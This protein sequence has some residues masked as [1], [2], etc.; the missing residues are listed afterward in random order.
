MILLLFFISFLLSENTIN[1]AAIMGLGGSEKQVENSNLNISSSSSQQQQYHRFDRLI[2]SV[3]RKSGHPDIIHPTICPPSCEHLH[4]AIDHFQNGDNISLTGRIKDECSCVCPVSRPVYLSSAGSCVSKLLPTECERTISW[5]TLQ[6]T[7]T[8]VPVVHLLPHSVVLPNSPLN[9]EK[10]GIHVSQNGQVNCTIGQVFY[11]N[12]HHRWKTPLRKTVLFELTDFEQKPIIYFRGTDTDS[13]FLAGAVVQI[14]L[15][16]DRDNQINKNSQHFCISLRIAGVSGSIGG[17]GNHGSNSLENSSEWQTES[18]LLMI[19]V[20]FI[21]TMLLTT[22]FVWNICWKIKKRKMISDFQMQFIQQY[23]QQQNP[24]VIKVP[25]NQLSIED[26]EIEE[27]GN[28]ENN[29]GSGR[30]RLY[31]SAEYFDRDLLE[32]PP[33]MAE[34]FL[35]DLRR[36]VDVAKDRIRQR[37]YYPTLVRIDEEIE[38]EN[39]DG[40]E[41]ERKIKQPIMEQKQL[42]ELKQVKEE[43]EE[44]EEDFMIQS[45]SSSNKEESDSG[46]ESKEDSSEEEDK[47]KDK[48]KNVSEIRKN[49]ERPSQ[50]PILHNSSMKRRK[51][52][53]SGTVAQKQKEY[54]SKLRPPTSYS[55]RSLKERKGYAVYPNDCVFNKSL[56]RRPKKLAPTTQQ[57][58]NM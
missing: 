15:R 3:V 48:P 49:F 47:D 31:F 51:S 21:V 23:R 42:S 34:Q 24:E 45:T 58:D 22:F 55:G 36:M 20:C 52:A 4:K 40:N 6:P 1:G 27:G 2:L 41:K 9:F 26:I 44:E 5:K 11:E 30:R 19:F 43:E 35:M 18:I 53:P 54:E 32:N 50:L 13:S 17:N 16:C 56:P 57:T 33:P 29:G 12:V 10:E 7:E 38:Q 39:E 8:T 25:R 46:R 28:G 14:K 37:R